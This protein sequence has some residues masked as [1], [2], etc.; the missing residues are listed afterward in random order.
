M[1]IMPTLLEVVVEA[2]APMAVATR[3]EAAVAEVATAEVGTKEAVDHTVPTVEH[4]RT[5]AA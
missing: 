4:E 2:P 3:E 5:R 1:V